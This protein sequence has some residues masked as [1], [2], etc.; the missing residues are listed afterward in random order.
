MLRLFVL[1]TCAAGVARAAAPPALPEVKVARAI[2]R[3]V[4]GQKV[5]EARVEPRAT[6]RVRAQVSGQ[7]VRVHYREGSRVKKGDVLVEI[8]SRFARLALAKA[9]AAVKRAEAR[10]KLA[11]LARKRAKGEEAK[12]AGL[13]L[14]EAEADL[15]LAR[16]EVEAARLKVGLTRVR[17]P[18]DG[19]ARK[20]LAEVGAVVRADD[21]VLAAVDSV[22][23]VQIRVVAQ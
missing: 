11:A 7:V 20:R 14:M 3:T 8:D 15:S 23:S 6:V 2:F 21:T 5:Y 16:A 12:R 10:L 19:R 9:E 22:G 4:R 1:L 13:A 17:S 18:L